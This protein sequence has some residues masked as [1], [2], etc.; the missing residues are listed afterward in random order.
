MYRYVF[1]H[2]KIVNMYVLWNLKAEQHKIYHKNYSPH[3]FEI[4]N[5]NHNEQKYALETPPRS[6]KN[7]KSEARSPANE[8]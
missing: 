8:K 2:V 1:V 6:Q 7:S 4:Q 5:S 3:M